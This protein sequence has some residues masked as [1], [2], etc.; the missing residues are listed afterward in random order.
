ME[1]QQYNHWSGQYKK[2]EGQRQQLSG[3]LRTSALQANDE[4]FGEEGI[5]S[6]AN[7]SQKSWIEFN[8]CGSDIGVVLAPL[9]GGTFVAQTYDAESKA[10]RQWRHLKQVPFS[11]GLGVNDSAW[12]NI[13]PLDL[14]YMHAWSIFPD[15]HGQR[16]D[17]HFIHVQPYFSYFI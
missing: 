14:I 10:W 15:R 1:R 9:V 17:T 2:Q 11:S 3:S 7:Y 6:I 4:G 8:T 5:S 12:S 13:F 16:W